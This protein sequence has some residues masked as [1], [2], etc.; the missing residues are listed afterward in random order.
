MKQLI[1][2]AI[3]RCGYDLRRIGYSP[4]LMDFI[5]DRSIDVVLDVGG[6]VGQFGQSLRARG[7]RGKIISFE[8]ISAA[9]ATLAATAAGDGN[10]EV[11]NFAL[12]AAAGQASINVAV[13]SVFSSILPSSRAGARYDA[14]TAVSRHEVIE[15]RALDEVYPRSARN[16]MLKIDTQGYE[17]QV[18]EGGQSVLSLL[19]GVWM[20]LPI[21]HL[22]E[23]TWQLHEAI[24]FMAAAG[25]VPAQI[26]PVNYHSAD[27]VSL[28]EVDCLFRPRDARLD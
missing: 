3:N 24:A 5:R 4:D 23:G 26:H 6:N 13:E 16:V 9:F 2:Q 25:F 14:N 22:Y 17:R 11:N 1:R 21:V 7:Y 28:V 27:L 10:W 12:G 15:V 18:L 20:E 8:P 19:K